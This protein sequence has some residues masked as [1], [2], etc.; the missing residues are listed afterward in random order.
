MGIERRNTVTPRVRL[1]TALAP[2]SPCEWLAA[3]ALA[4]ADSGAQSI[5]DLN[6]RIAGA[7]D[8]AEALAAEIESATAQLAAAQEQAIAAA[9]GGAAERGARPGP[10]SAKRGSR[11]P[12]APPS[13][14]ARRRPR[15][16][17]A[18]ARRARRP[19]R[20]DLPRRRC[21][22]RPHSCSTPRAST[23]SRRAASTWSGSRRPT[24]RWS[25][26]VR[27]LRDAGRRSARRGRGRRGRARHSTSASPPPATRSPRCAPTAEAEAAALAAA[28]R[29]PRGRRRDL[30]R[31][32]GEWTDQ[33]ARLERI[34]ERQARGGRRVVRRLGDPGVDR[35]VRVRRQLGR[36]Q[37]VA[38]AP[39]ART[40]SCLRPGSSTAA[41]ATPRT[42][43]PPSSPRS[44][45]RS[46]R[47]RATRP[48]S[49]DRG[50]GDRLAASSVA[51]VR[52]KGAMTA[53]PGHA[54]PRI[55]RRSTSPRGLALGDRT[56]IASTSAPNT[57][58][59]ILIWRPN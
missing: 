36:G 5:D 52:S 15:Q 29:R 18:L 55:A 34:S 53:F 43:P 17:P 56:P 46:G 12:S 45:P 11:P 42:P 23:I 7:R 31:Q 30:Q 44:Q 6:S 47:T 19:S 20:R 25:P 26:R 8:Q 22:T 33:V 59:A 14:R 28:P 50:A 41:R 58:P 1:A 48:G 40:R 4:T 9:S 27:T 21:P 3:F 2:C 51:C 16:A 37:P 54:Y 39:A 35:D 49:A 24:P 32:V 13:R 10:R 38:P 57:P